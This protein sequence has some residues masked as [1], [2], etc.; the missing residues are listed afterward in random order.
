MDTVSPFLFRQK[1]LSSLDTTS[2]GALVR[3]AAQW[4]AKSPFRNRIQVKGTRQ[5]GEV[6]QGESGRWFTISN[7]RS[8]PAKAPDGDSIN[9]APTTDTPATPAAGDRV[10]GTGST[11][12]VILRGG[13][14]Y[15]NA[16]KAEASV[17][18]LIG[19]KPGVA[20]GREEGGKIVTPHFPY[21]ISVDVIPQEKRHLYA[22][23][24]ARNLPAIVNAVSLL[25]DA[26][27]DYN[28]PIQVGFDK[29]GKTASVFDFSA[30]QQTGRE[31]AAMNNLDHLAN[32]LKQFGVS[33]HAAAVSRVR[34]VMG[35]ID[36]DA[37]ML[38]SDSPEALDGE[39]IDGN[40]DG[41]PPKYAYYAFNAR[42]IPSVA[43]TEHRDGVKV[44]FSPVPLTDEF[45]GQW[46]IL[47]AIHTTP[48]RP[49][50]K[51][52][53]CI[54]PSPFRYRIK[55]LP[56]QPQQSEDDVK[57]QLIAEILA[58]VFGEDNTDAKSLEWDGKAAKGPKRAKGEVWEGA[59][60]RWFT[61]NE[62]GK[63]VPTKRPAGNEGS[64]PSTLSES[65]GSAAATKPT[66]G[67]PSATKKP[68]TPK[69]V[70]LT[71]D[72]AKQTVA[73]LK[74]QG[75]TEDTLNM[76]VGSL[77]TLTVADLKQLHKEM[78]IKGGGLKADLIAKIKDTLTA[79]KD[80]DAPEPEPIP[81]ATPTP[82]ATPKKPSTPKAMPRVIDPAKIP[83]SMAKLSMENP[84]AVKSTISKLFKNVKG[85]KPGMVTPEHVVSMIGAPDDAEITMRN[86]GGS[87]Y[88]DMKHPS[89]KKYTC[90]MMLNNDKPQILNQSI[91]IADNMTGKG[92]GTDLLSRQ[93]AAASVAGVSKITCTASGAKG[94]GENGYYTW[95][96]LGFD[97][98]ISKL[99]RDVIKKA[100]KAYPEAKRVSD[101]MKTPEGRAWWKEN[102]DTFT[103]DFDLKPTSLSMS[104]LD[105]YV[106]AKAGKDR[107]AAP[108]PDDAALGKSEYEPFV[109]DSRHGTEGGIGK[110]RLNG[111]E[112]FFK[113][114]D[115]ELSANESTAASVA[116]MCGVRVPAARTAKLPNG[117]DGI[118]TEWVEGDTLIHR[119]YSKEGS[120][121]ID[122]DSIDRHL[123]FTFLTALR[124]RHVGNYMID[125]SGNLISID[126]EHS[127]GVPPNDD[128]EEQ[129]SECVG[130]AEILDLRDA[131]KEFNRDIIK[132]V[133]GKASAVA[134][135]LTS[136]GRTDAAAAVLKRGESLLRLAN[137]P[138]DKLNQAF[139]R[140]E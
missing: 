11:G 136:E 36:A 54:N 42:E 16:T 80:A 70:K 118:L 108:L 87:L 140:R 74:Q 24:V 126:H 9:P 22:P 46:E 29:G 41:Q 75:P 52:L 127:F 69:P 28:D 8:V 84:T 71:L 137:G 26:G 7:G 83:K 67:K 5:E 15:K 135:K 44:I 57:A 21:V 92:I 102:G 121:D 82:A 85:F 123:A 125:K 48:E 20:A 139:R 59:K 32:Y 63:V 113:S 132:E 112:Y 68:A 18:A 116:E 115:S 128:A 37:R 31:E 38:D 6:W 3:P 91:Y 97:A 10:I 64:A 130:E 124:D 35:Y 76:L 19:G 58:G 111:K 86:I 56:S 105:N 107:T 133:A 55:A 65:R 33:R 109:Q 117:N 12:E 39:R 4:S 1:A 119:M 23:I 17:Y 120:P 114:L 96:A 62:D 79:V 122:T 129:G 73:E 95:A 93:V 90:V 30:V 50:E 72:Q 45:M 14:V 134:D 49:T 99:N 89:V 34:D 43:Q 101:I 103:A 106:K 53:P 131:S 60:N 138:A 66:D 13:E 104:L 110:V 40:L 94:S 100:K 77:A 78:G 51:S 81:D 27:Y 98:P 88:I 2:G 61:V 47:P 25:T